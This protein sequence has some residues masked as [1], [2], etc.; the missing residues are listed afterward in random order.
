M[1]TADPAIRHVASCVPP[2]LEGVLGK[3]PRAIGLGTKAPG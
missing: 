3:Q 2:L 1:T